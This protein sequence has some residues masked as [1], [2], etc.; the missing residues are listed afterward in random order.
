MLEM[1]TTSQHRVVN[2]NENRTVFKRTTC[3]NPPVSRNQNIGK[4]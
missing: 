4:Y 3:K 1:Q 2:S